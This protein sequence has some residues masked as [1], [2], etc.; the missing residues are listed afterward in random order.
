MNTGLALVVDDE[1]TNRFILKSLLK[2]NNFDVIEAI[3]GSQAID[4]FLEK[5]P[6]IIFMDIMM[7]VMDGYAATEKIKSLSKEKFIPVIFLTAMTNEESLNKCIASGGDDFLT[8]PFNK[9]ILMS[10]IQSMRRI[11]DLI[12]QTTTLKDMMQRDEEVA[13]KVF[14]TAITT[15]NVQPDS[16]RSIL[17]PAGLFSG[18]MILTS[19]TPSHDLDILIGDFTGHGLSAAIGALPASEIFHAMSKKGFTGPQILER[20]NEKLNLILPTGMFMAA[21]FVR[22]RHELDHIE[23]CNCGMPDIL[24]LD[25]DKRNIKHRIPSRTLPLG[26]TTDFTTSPSFQ[27]IPLKTGDRVVLFS[28]GAIESRNSEGQLFGQAQLESALQ[29]STS[30]FAIDSGFSSIKAHNHECPQDD[31][32][33]LIEVLCSP[34]LLPIWDPE[35]TNNNRKSDRDNFALDEISMHLKYS[36]QRLRVAYPIPAIINFIKSSPGFDKHYQALFT[37]LTELFLNSLDHGILQLDSSLKQTAL[38]FSEYF[39]QRDMHLSKLNDGH[40]HISITSIPKPYGADIHILIED[41]G[42]GFNYKNTDL[43]QA[44][45][46]TVKYCGRGI[47]L[48]RDLCSSL[49]YKGNG[50]TVEAIY[51][52]KH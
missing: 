47:N 39:A 19:Y 17:Q 9:T 10:K 29:F 5:S 16:L 34:R 22:I 52:L 21:Q 26:I 32:I 11:Q 35:N 14:N 4:I 23:A 49:C 25:S 6:D 33:S 45:F 7:P 2:K 40:I 1:P 12:T 31:D 18:D 13:E 46:E 28:D 30:E 27:Y 41:S 48:V 42:V 51:E 44:D 37:I 36:G 50:N 8:K 43:T 3:D 15:D 24:I 20:I 38:G